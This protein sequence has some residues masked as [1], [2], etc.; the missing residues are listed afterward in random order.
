MMR[1]Q[2]LV[3]G[4][5]E[6]DVILSFD[7]ADVRHGMDEGR[8]RSDHAGPDGV[9][10]E[11]PRVLELLE[12]SER[13]LDANAAVGLAGRRVAQLAQSGMAGAG[14]VPAVGRLA[15][16]TGGDLEHADREPR[17]ETLEQSRQARGHD[18]AADEQHVDGLARRGRW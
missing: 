9:R 12:D 2:R 18:A 11:L 3:P 4:D 1:A 6:V 8:R 17:L 7:E 5:Q 14:V 16:K 15:R 10:P 13:P